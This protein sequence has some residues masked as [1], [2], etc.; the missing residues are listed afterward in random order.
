[1][2]KKT[3]FN[4]KVLLDIIELLNTDE[5][6]NKLIAFVILNNLE[7]NFNSNIQ[8]FYT[9]M[10]WFGYMGAYCHKVESCY[11]PERAFANTVCKK[12]KFKSTHDNHLFKGYVTYDLVKKAKRFARK[13]DAENLNN[14]INSL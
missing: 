7:Y 10:L 3:K 9:E 11:K 4:L 5:E 12:F 6:S 8:R 1:M 2:E 13:Y 14:L